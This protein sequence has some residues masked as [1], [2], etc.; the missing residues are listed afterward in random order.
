[1]PPAPTRVAAP[2]PSAFEPTPTANEA[3]ARTKSALVTVVG[4][5][6]KGADVSTG[7]GFFVDAI[8][9]VVTSYRVVKGT[10]SQHVLLPGSGGKIVE[11][12]VLAADEERDLAL[13]QTSI[14]PPAPV[15]VLADAAA[16]LS[17]GDGVVA[18]GIAGKGGPLVD[19][20]GRIVGISV[21]LAHDAGSVAVPIE[22]VRL[23]VDGAR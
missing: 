21:Q 20:R 10:D 19:R 23:F 17:S 12:R 7:S 9:R 4:R 1:A 2:A 18:L 3:L 15:A 6:S 11:A 8:G 13:L 5:S 22:D 16:G 14:A